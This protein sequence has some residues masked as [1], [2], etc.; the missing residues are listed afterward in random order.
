MTGGRHGCVLLN[1]P[2]TFFLGDF[3]V[4]HDEPHQASRGQRA[5]EEV[6]LPA[7]EQIARV[8]DHAGGRDHRIPIVDRL[9]HPWF[10]RA[11][12][13]LQKRVVRAVGDDGPAVIFPRFRVVQLVATPGTML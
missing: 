1:H 4:L 2:G 10:R 5:D 8:N 12:A 9:L 6:V 7:R 11:F 3:A 13:N